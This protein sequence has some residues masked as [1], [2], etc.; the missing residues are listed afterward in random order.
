[1]LLAGLIVESTR[2]PETRKEIIRCVV[3]STWFPVLKDNI[4]FPVRIQYPRGCETV[5]RGILFSV[6]RDFVVL[7]TFTLHFLLLKSDNRLYSR[8]NLDSKSG[9]LAQSINKMK[10]FYLPSANRFID[11]NRSKAV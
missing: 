3:D 2:F 5:E 6:A 7:S 9:Y 8:P 4:L 11:M 1:L 10:V